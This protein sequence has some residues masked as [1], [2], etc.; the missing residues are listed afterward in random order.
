MKKIN[1]EKG[2]LALFVTIAMLFFMMFLLV[3]YIST[4]NEQ[5]TQLAITTRIKETYEEK[6]SN[7]SLENIYEGF[8]GKDAYIPIYTVE[9]LKKVGS[10]ESVYISEVK[11]YYTF[12]LDSNY[13]LKNDIDLNKGKYTI[14]DSGEV[15]FSSDAEQWTPIGTSSSSFT[16][17]FDGNSYKISGLYINNTSL[18]NQG[19]FGY[20]SGTIQNLTVDNGYINGA[21]YLGGIV[22]QNINN[23]NIIKC[24]NK[25]KINGNGYAGGIF[26]YSNSSNTIVNNCYNTASITG[27]QAGGIGGTIENGT[28][29]NCYSIGNIS[30]ISYSGG[31][32]GQSTNSNISNCYYLTGTATGGINGADVTG[33]AEVK[34]AAEMKTSDFVTL[35]NNG[36]NNWKL[37]SEENNGYPILNYQS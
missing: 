23:G 24:V 14:S 13:I 11:A 9:Q 4:T 28:I 10:G 37:V 7:E 6:L 2:S 15:T 25:N 19:L 31:I 35:L 17:I 32:V 18:S 3:L 22:G 1:N 26:G 30:G 36:E 16:G 33:Q 8:V 20:N 21:N 12:N 5:K 34:K 29:K 27:N